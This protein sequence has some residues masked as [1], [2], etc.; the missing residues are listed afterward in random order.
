MILVE[1][2]EPISDPVPTVASVP[3][4][5]SMYIKTGSIGRVELLGVDPMR[6]VVSTHHVLHLRIP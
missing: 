5:F 4:S 2:S 6:H 3:Y 1:V